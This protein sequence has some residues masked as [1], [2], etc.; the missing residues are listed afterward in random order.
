VFIDLAGFDRNDKAKAAWFQTAF[1]APG[2]G[3]TTARC[4]C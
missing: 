1:A 4:S 2:G 3:A